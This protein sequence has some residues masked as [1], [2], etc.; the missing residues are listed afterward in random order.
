[1]LGPDPAA[2]QRLRGTDDAGQG[3]PASASPTE[4]SAAH[5]LRAAD[6]GNAGQDAG[7]RA[8]TSAYVS[9]RQHTSANGQ[10]AGAGAAL[11]A[12]MKRVAGRIKNALQGKHCHHT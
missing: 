2:G 4:R 3:A 9:I 1:V 11:R 8:H 7:A 5:C 10:D 6:A 12:K